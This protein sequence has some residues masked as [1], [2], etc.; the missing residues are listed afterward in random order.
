MPGR[1]CGLVIGT[2]GVLFASESL[3]RLL[4]GI[5]PRDPGTLAG[6]ATMFTAV[7]LLACYLPARLATR[8]S[9]VI[10]LSAE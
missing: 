10:A 3:A 2:A 5:E 9:P 8:I 6:V 7:A 4:F 1:V